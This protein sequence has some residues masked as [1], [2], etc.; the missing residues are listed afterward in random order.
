M[1][2]TI[3]FLKWADEQVKIPPGLS[4]GGASAPQFLADHLTLSQPGEGGAHYPLPVQQAPQIFRL[5]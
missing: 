5:G 2:I 4:Q 3:F 1:S